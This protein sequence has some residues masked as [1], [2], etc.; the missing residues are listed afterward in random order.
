MSQFEY[1]MVLVSIIMGL[2]ITTLLAGTAELAKSRTR[3]LYWVHLVWVLTLLVWHIGVWAQR[4]SMRVHSIWT[5]QD[6]WLFL[7]VPILLFTLSSLCFPNPDEPPSAME[8]FYYLNA[9]AFFGTA[10]ALNA[11]V[12]ATL[13]VF[14]GVA[15][16]S[17]DTAAHGLG[18]ALSVFLAVTRRRRIHALAA[19]ASFVAIFVGVS[20]YDIG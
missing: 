14:Y 16:V 12:A 3:K 9:P 2:G 4:W 17:W 1:L 11:A 15:V 8:D 7:F 13:I 20:K 18:V 10:A 5:F 19:V 6:V